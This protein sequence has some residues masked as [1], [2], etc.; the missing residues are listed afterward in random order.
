MR[1]RAEVES[2]IKDK[3]FEEAKKRLGEI[4]RRECAAVYIDTYAALISAYE[5]RPQEMLEVLSRYGSSHVPNMC[6]AEYLV[7]EKEIEDGVAYYEKAL[8]LCDVEEDR[9]KIV[10]KTVILYVHARR[11]SE[12]L[13]LA[14][15]LFYRFYNK[16]NIVLLWLVCRTAEG[17][18]LEIREEARRI[19][20]KIEFLVNRKQ[21]KMEIS[22]FGK[23]TVETKNR[24]KDFLVLNSI[25]VGGAKEIEVRAEE[26]GSR[27][28]RQ[29]EEG[30]YAGLFEEYA[31]D[32]GDH[33]KDEDKNTAE[34]AIRFMKR[35]ED[36]YLLEAIGERMY[37]D[38]MYW[39]TRYIFRILIDL[40]EKIDKIRY[41]GL[42]MCVN[43]ESAEFAKIAKI[44]P[45]SHPMFRESVKKYNLSVFLADKGKGLR[46]K[47]IEEA[48]KEGFPEIEVKDPYLLR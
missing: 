45:K 18:C 22:A 39:C 25:D 41:T 47:E 48:L 31:R 7:D 43:L 15:S 11:F 3:R 28:G 37:K 29:I 40:F 9:E 5:N 38:E 1:G 2:L 17:S 10:R 13:K 46:R 35:S 19:E 33:I 34:K 14:K 27:Y 24:F 44:D 4:D 32:S 20:E 6:Y 8:R 16:Y 12:A 23:I 30:D 42:Q 26:A 21:C 36:I